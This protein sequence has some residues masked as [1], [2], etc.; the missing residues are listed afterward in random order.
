MAW[1][2]ATQPEA[3]NC[4]SMQKI[5][6]TGYV[7]LLWESIG[8]AN[9]FSFAAILEVKVRQKSERALADLREQTADTL[10]SDLGTVALVI[11]CSDL[12]ITEDKFMPIAAV[13]RTPRKGN[14]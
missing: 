6:S 7:R 8:K 14:W 5:D 4:Q 11:K 10:F 9:E 1:W 2:D 3:M 12:S 13:F